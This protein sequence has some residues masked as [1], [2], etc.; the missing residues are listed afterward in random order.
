[1]ADVETIERSTNVAISVALSA[2]SVQPVTVRFSTR[3]GTALAGEDYF[4]QRGELMFSPGMKTQFINLTIR[5]DVT[6]EPDEYLLVTL[7]SVSNA[8]L[9]RAQATITIRNDDGLPGEVHS[10]EFDPIPS[11]QYVGR[12]IPV[13]I[14]A[15]DLAG[16]F[17]S[18]FTQRV[19]FS[20]TSMATPS[21]WFNFE[22]NS[23]VGWTPLNGGDP[24]MPSEVAFFDVAGDGV[25]SL[26]FRLMPGHDPPGDGLMRQVFLSGGIPYSISADFALLNEQASSPSVTASAFLHAGSSEIGSADLSHDAFIGLWPGYT[27]RAAISGNFTPPRDGF[28][29][30]TVSIAGHSSDPGLWVY[31]DNIRI[32]TPPLVLSVTNWFTNG[33]WAGEATFTN[34]AAQVA[35]E[36]VDPEGHSGASGEFDLR[37]Q[38]DLG[39]DTVLSAPMPNVGYPIVLTL[40]VTNRGPLNAPEVRLTSRIAGNLVVSSATTSLGACLVE[41]NIVSCNLGAAGNG[42]RRTVTIVASAAVSGWITNVAT[43]DSTETDAFTENNSSVTPLLIQPA[44]VYIANTTLRE[45]E[46]EATNATVAV[47]LEYPSAQWISVDYSTLSGSA[48]AGTDFLSTAGQVVFPPGSLTQFVTVQVLGDVIDEATEFFS[49]ALANPTN[50][51]IASPGS[52]TVTITDNDPPPVLSVADTIVVEGDSLTTQAVFA[53]SLS[54]PSGQTVTASWATS[55]GSAVAGADYLAIANGTV[56]FPPGVTNASLS[57]LVKGDLLNESNETFF[58]TL[59]SPLKAT[60][61]RAT[62]L[63]TILNDDAVPGRLD[64]F[65]LGAMPSEQLA[66]RPFTVTVTALDAFDLPVTNYSGSPQFRAV[67]PNN[68][69]VPF[70]GRLLSNFVAGIW[71]GSLTISNPYP[72]LRLVVDDLAAHVGTSAAFATVRWLSLRL[73]LPA[74]RTEGDGI[75]QDQAQLTVALARSNDVVFRLVSSDVSELVVPTTVTLPAGQTSTVFSATVVDDLELDG[76]RLVTV[77]ATAP[78]YATN[79]ATVLIHD[80]ESN[81]TL[82]L[83]LVIIGQDVQLEFQSVAGTWYRVETSDLEGPWAPVASDQLGTGG[84][85]SIVDSGA[86]RRPRSLYRLV[87]SP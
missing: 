68:S 77:S 56:S 34:Q 81:A 37:P 28:Y 5:G 79:T 75:L 55:D 31:M 40:S 73:S 52:G 86:L 87:L 38:A 20:T 27:Y 42:D 15:R 9:G 78:D 7:S 66:M 43:V 29:P 58:V 60:L 10:F 50:A 23:L 11:T 46:G 67:L 13:R 4:S 71:E 12:A 45:P 64:H 51:V 49:V 72:S 17:V 61:G 57:V 14:T 36:V 44:P 80:N 48:L 54:V 53:V 6:I 21:R 59:R 62:A 24:P 26:A 85:L 83:A 76:S 2:T 32:H 74:E 3:N 70:S 8:T 65:G 47:F 25:A 35:L 69:T 19:A 22:T 63:A 33:V 82:R 39:V 30:L 84:K 16:N 18:N 41:S 1:V